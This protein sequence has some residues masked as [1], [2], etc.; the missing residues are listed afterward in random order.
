L[1]RNN[2]SCVQWQQTTGE[3]TEDGQLTTENS[4]CR[5]LHASSPTGAPGRMVSLHGMCRMFGMLAFMLASTLTSSVTIWHLSSLSTRPIDGHVT[6]CWRGRRENRRR[7][8]EVRGVELWCHTASESYWC[9]LNGSG[10]TGS[11]FWAPSSDISR[12]SPK[13]SVSAR[14]NTVT[15]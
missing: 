7:L 1:R 2:A 14:S 11:P 4:I 12:C 8:V 10:P 5:Q 6:N 9:T 3:K 13:V 15:Q